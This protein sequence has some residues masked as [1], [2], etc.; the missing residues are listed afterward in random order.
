MS[1]ETHALY[2]WAKQYV[3]NVEA[4]FVGDSKPTDV[5]RMAAGLIKAVKEYEATIALRRGNRK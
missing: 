4:A 3:A 5:E 2:F 1:D